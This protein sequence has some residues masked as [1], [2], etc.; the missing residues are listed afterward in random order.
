M[1]LSAYNVTRI[2]AP[3]VEPIRLLTIEFDGLTLY[4]C[5]RIWGSGAERCLFDD[6]VY[7]PLILSWNTIDHGKIDPI[8]YTLEPSGA[9]FA[10]D[11]TMPVGGAANFTAL[12]ASHDP[13][14]ATI[15]VSEILDGEQV[16]VAG[17]AA[18]IDFTEYTEVDAGGRVAVIAG[19]ITVA[20]MALGEV[21]YVYKALTMPTVFKI[22]LK[23]SLNNDSY[24]DKTEM[25]V[26]GFGDGI[27][28]IS[29]C[30][31]GIFV[32]WFH[33]TT[34]IM[35][36][37]CIIGGN[38]TQVHES[39]FASNTNYYLTINYDNT[40][41]DYGQLL[42]AIY[43]D[44]A[45]TILKETLTL[46]LPGLMPELAYHYVLSSLNS[47]YNT[48]TNLVVQDMEMETFPTY[49]GP[50]AADKIDLFKG[51]IEDFPS[52]ATDRVEITCSG[53]ELDIAH[54]FPVSICNTT[55]YAGAD[56]D[57]IGKMLPVV[58]GQ[59]RKVPALAVDAGGKTTIVTDWTD[60]SPGNSGTADVTDGAY[61]PSG[62]FILQIDSEQISIASRAGNTLTLAAADARAYDS[63]TAVDHDLGSACAEIQTS[64]VYTVAAHPVKAIDAVYVDNIRQTTGFTAYTGQTGDEL[65]GYEDLAVVAFSALPT[66]LKQVNVDINNTLDTDDAGHDHTGS[67]LYHRWN[68]DRIASTSGTITNANNIIDGSLTT[69]TGFNSHLAYVWMNSIYNQNPGGIPIKI[70]LGIQCHTMLAGNTIAFGF[71]GQSLSV[72]GAAASNNFYQSNWLTLSSSFNTWAEVNAAYAMVTQSLGSGSI[73]VIEIYAE[74]E[75][76]PEA[77]EDSADVSLT[78]TV[79]MSGNTTAETVIGNRVS[80]DVDG[81]QDDGAGTYTGTPAAL[82]ERPDHI[83]KHLLI[84]LCGLTSAEIDATTYAAAGTFYNTNSY[85]LAFAILA[86]PNVRDLAGRIAHQSKSIEYW[87]AGVHHLKH[88]PASESTDKTLTAHRIDLSQ[89]W[90]SYTDRANILNALSARH[91]RDW[92]GCEDDAEA[93]RA[94]VI[95]DDSTSDTKYGTLVGEQLTYPYIIGAAQAQAVLDWVIGDLAAPRLI[96]EL[97]GGYYLADIQRGQTIAFV[98]DADSALD[99]ALLGLVTST[100]DQ[101]RVIDRISRPD[102]AL[103]I[104]TIKI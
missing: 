94:V 20:D 52:M 39:G 74:F 24:L 25:A 70:R 102:G 35:A 2:D 26:C 86:R 14:Y 103:Q 67:N 56:P 19:T 21:G 9:G 42:C 65:A 5:D 23:T 30:S 28:E 88:I 61:L 62:A 75:Y 63:T 95:A 98:F 71:C 16:D 92:S 64:Y 10:V 73:G 44:S 15:T 38:K 101:F 43:T 50:V 87:A 36:I 53:M 100:T 13:H 77:H 69:Y 37:N 27:D 72:G 11:N 81:Y 31:N 99:K 97:A 47:I 22:D 33:Q 29:E 1:S 40:I 84:A 34:Y 83:L 78:G 59:A 8:D 46:D 7:E 76:A 3:A 85:T 82:I 58:Y 57:D 17:A 96:I 55:D 51:K 41:G 90:I 93:D 91:A 104:Q 6:Q 54:R 12:F 18:N 60:T 48:D 4:L 80:A 66:F 49:K 45:R 79:T 89:I 32:Q 68:I